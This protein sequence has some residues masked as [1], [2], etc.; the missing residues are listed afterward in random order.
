MTN[1]DILGKLDQLLR[2]TTDILAEQRRQADHL[3]QHAGQLRQ[4]TNQLERQADQIAGLRAEV[5]RIDGRISDMPT[6]RDFGRL[7][8]RV[9]EMSERL[10]TMIGYVPP[11]PAAE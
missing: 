3:E 9:A 5:A 4:Q 2:M 1:S 10:P 6:T 7:E 11:K 8:G